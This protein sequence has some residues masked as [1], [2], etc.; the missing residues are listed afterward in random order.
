MKSPTLGIQIKSIQENSDNWLLVGSKA[1][2]KTS[3]N[4]SAVFTSRR[5]LKVNDVNEPDLNFRV[6]ADPEIDLD[7]G[8]D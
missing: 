7:A 4:H 8:P 3:V 1:L 6:S 2:G 5:G